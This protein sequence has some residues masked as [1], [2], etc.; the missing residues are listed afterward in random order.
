MRFCQPHWDSLRSA[1]ED[2][3]LSGLVPTDSHRAAEN[4]ARTVGGDET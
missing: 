3:G 1:L 4:L 2:R